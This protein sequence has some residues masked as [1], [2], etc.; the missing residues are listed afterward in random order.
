MLNRVEAGIRAFDPCLSCSTH[1][2]GQM[3]LIVRLIAARRRGP[4][5]GAAPVTTFLVIGYGNELRGDDAVGPCVAGRVAGWRRPEVDGLAV[6]QLRPNWRRCSRAEMVVFVDAGVEDGERK[7]A[8][9]RLEAGPGAVDGPSRPAVAAGV[10]GGALWPAAG[11]VAGDD[12]GG[13]LR[14]GRAALGR[15]P[16]GGGRS[17]LRQIDRLVRRRG[18]P[19]VGRSRWRQMVA[20]HV[21]RFRVKAQGSR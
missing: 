17:A 7:V 8:F 11:G 9:G 6:H 1:A 14:A 5:R 13:R 4:A 10:G 19:R 20:R 2:A 12:P 18:N 16:S 21:S 15:G 3:P